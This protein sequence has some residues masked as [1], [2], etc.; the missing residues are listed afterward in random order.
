MKRIIILI[1]LALLLVGCGRSEVINF[2][3]EIK[4]LEHH[5]EEF[6]TGGG[7]IEEFRKVVETF[8]AKLEKLGDNDFAK[9]QREANEKRLEAFTEMDREKINESTALQ[10]QALEIYNEIKDGSN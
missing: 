1:V 8:N 3:E 9:I 10:A 2:D 4:A 7:D 5:T 6:A